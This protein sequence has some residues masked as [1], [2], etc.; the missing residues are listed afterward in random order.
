MAFRDKAKKVRHL[1]F[2]YQIDD[3]GGQ[4]SRI[5]TTTVEDGETVR[6]VQ[7]GM[8]SVW[9]GSETSKCVRV[10]RRDFRT[11]VSIDV[12]T[13]TAG[14]SEVPI[15]MWV[16]EDD[17]YTRIVSKNVVLTNLT[18]DEAEKRDQVNVAVRGHSA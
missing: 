4:Y 13:T 1:E 9:I 5:L 7:Q 6:R 15:A 8:D 2:R 10:Y 12:Q 16:A 18:I 11:T 14:V 17:K 3:L